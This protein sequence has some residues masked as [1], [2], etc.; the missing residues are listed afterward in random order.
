MNSSGF[1]IIRWQSSG[2]SVTLRS[3]FTTG[4][5][6]VRFGTKCPS[7]IS[8]WMTL[9]PPSLAA[10]TC[11]PR[12]AKSAERI[13]GASSIKGCLVELLLRTWARVEIL[14]EVYHSK[15]LSRDDSSLHQDQSQGAPIG[16]RSACRRML[17]SSDMPAAP[18]FVSAAYGLAAVLAWG[19]SD[20]LGGYATR[21]ANAFLFTAVVN[22]GG[23]LVVGTLASATHAPFP[24]RRSVAWALA[25]GVSGGAALAIFFRAL[26]SGRMGLTAPVAAVLGAA[27]P[28]VF[29]MFTEGCARHDSLSRLRLCR[30]RTLAHHPHR[31]WRH[32]RRDRARRARRHRVRRILSLR[33]PGRRRFGLLDRLAHPHWRPDHHRPRSS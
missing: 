11:S 7:I 26:S 29:S 4:G 5:P 10:R 3:D 18:Q 9:A 20:F 22:L 13:E 24:S 28:A 16:S 27:I 21:R 33:P 25:G 17:P 6:I 31:R 2:N 14:L 12:R 1:S 19:T 15:R 30:R 23:L 32:A 8:T